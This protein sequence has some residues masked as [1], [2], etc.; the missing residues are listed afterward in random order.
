MSDA[1]PYDVENWEI[2]A[3][4]PNL[5]VV[6][7]KLSPGQKVPWHIHTQITDTFFCL[8]G[9]M[10]IEHVGDLESVELNVGESHVVLPNTPHQVGGKDGG[11]C[12]FEIVQ[13]IGTYDFVPVDVE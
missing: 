6:I 11:P 12:K 8:E 7:F 10:V 9:P 13:G 2:V 4:V 3:Q 1:L 5:R